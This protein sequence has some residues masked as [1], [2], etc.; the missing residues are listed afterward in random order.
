MAAGIEGI[1]GQFLQNQPP[2]SRCRHA[3]FLL[4]AINISEQRPV[5]AL[6]HFQIRLIFVAALT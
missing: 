3:G 6:G 1:V 5:M 2:Q 4:Q